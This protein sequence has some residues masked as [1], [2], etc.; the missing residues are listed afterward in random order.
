MGILGNLLGGFVQTR[1]QSRGMWGSG[2]GRGRSTWGGSYGRARQPGFFGSSMG[3]MAM[4]GM[5]AWLARSYMN[6]RSMP[7]P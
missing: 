3:R 6:R 4:G 7:R 5:A 2:Y 1:R